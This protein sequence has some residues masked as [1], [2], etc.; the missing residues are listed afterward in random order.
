[1]ICAL[2]AWLSRVFGFCFGM[3]R[4]W[5]AGGEIWLRE[6]RST[7]VVLKE[8]DIR[9]WFWFPEMGFVVVN[10]TTVAGHFERL[11]DVDG[12]LIRILKDELQIPEKSHFDS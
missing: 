4:F 6:G 5:L 8:N 2:R 1:M 7:R 10:V 9:E 3:R 12:S 11:I